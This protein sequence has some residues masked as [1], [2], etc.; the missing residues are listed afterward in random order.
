M[1]KHSF[2]RI[3]MAALFLGGLVQVAQ[4][5]TITGALGANPRA[6]DEWYLMC[7]ST[8]YYVAGTVRETSTPGDATQINL[9]IVSIHR[10]EGARN[11]TAPNTGGNAPWVGLVKGG[12]L[13]RVIVNKTGATTEAYNATVHCLNKQGV[14]VTAGEPILIQNM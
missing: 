13:Y 12:G 4:A 9:Q 11:I 14:E 5:H 6:T 2:K 7:P 3:G 10:P 8:T 1:K